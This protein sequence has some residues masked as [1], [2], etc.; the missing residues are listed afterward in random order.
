MTSRPFNPNPDFYKPAANGRNA[1]SY[2]LDV[3]VPDFKF[4]QTWRSNIAVDRRLPWGLVGTGEFIYNSD[5][6]G[7]KYI[8]ANL[9]AAQSKFTGPDAR[10]RWV[11]TP[12]AANGQAGGCVT[13]LNN[14]PGNQV[15][16]DANNVAGFQFS[17]NHDFKPTTI[18][19][20][21]TGIG[22]EVN[23]NIYVVGI[24]NNPIGIICRAPN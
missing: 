22:G 7:I 4:P 11:G 19:I 18:S 21:N 6:N 3:T 8:N 13:R 10:P 12:C 16:L 17:V 9:P 2:E 23:P 15:T 24:V 5:V 1:P 14:D 20:Q